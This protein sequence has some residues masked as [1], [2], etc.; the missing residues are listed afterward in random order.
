MN[1]IYSQIFLKEIRQTFR[2]VVWGIGLYFWLV[3]KNKVEDAFQ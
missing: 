1:K 3:K 2:V